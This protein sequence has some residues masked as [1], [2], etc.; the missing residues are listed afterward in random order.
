MRA[1]PP[2]L[3]LNMQSALF[4]VPPEPTRE[5]ANCAAAQIAAEPVAT[6]LAIGIRRS[7]ADSILGSA[8]SFCR[9]MFALRL[10][11]LWYF[12][13]AAWWALILIVSFKYA[14]LILRAGNQGEGGIMAL[15]A[16]L[17]VRH[18][19]ARSWRAS[20]LIFGLIGAV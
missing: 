17:D 19:P 5:L 18:A 3:L 10:R 7:I 9:V 4:D 15:L 14:I 11:S 1:C 16:L 13:D 12:F 2:V 8:S 20:L 6:D